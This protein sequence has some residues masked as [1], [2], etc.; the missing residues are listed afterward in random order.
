MTESSRFLKFRESRQAAVKLEIAAEEFF[1]PL[2][3]ETEKTA[4]G[5]YLQQRIRPAVEFLIQRENVE[6]LGKLF[7]LG[8]ISPSMLD[9][10]LKTASENGKNSAFVWLLQLKK[11]SLGF[12]ARDFSL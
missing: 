5:A 1:N 9:D 7:T 2:C 3:P 10:F 6:G 11:E 4:Y 12:S 8:W